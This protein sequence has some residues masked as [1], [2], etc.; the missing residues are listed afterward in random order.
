MNQISAHP[1]PPSGETGLLLNA[2]I[3]WRMNPPFALDAGTMEDQ[4]AM[5]ARCIAA[6]IRSLA[7]IIGDQP[8]DYVLCTTML[9]SAIGGIQPNAELFFDVIERECGIRPSAIVNTYMCVGWGYALR[10]FSKHSNAR[11]VMM[12]IVDVDIHHLRWHTNPPLVGKSGFGVGT[13]LMTLPEDRSD[14]AETGGPFPDSAFKDM[15]WA[16][17][18]RY[19]KRGKS[20]TFGPFLAGDMGTML[21]RVLGGDMLAPNRNDRLGHCFGCDPWV[22]VIEYLQRNSLTAPQQ[23]VLSAIAFNGYYVVCPL[24]LLPETHVDFRV[25]DADVGAL[26]EVIADYLA[27]KGSPRSLAQL[28][29]PQ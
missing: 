27:G 23:V 29:E 12:T 8:T 2:A 7:P 26:K 22:G 18:S 1:L 16:L 6:Q 25:S 4:I 21:Q 11:R 24:Q 5:L 15:V 14:T 28:L 17:R 13:M 9:T 20:Y 19:A 3:Y 10:F